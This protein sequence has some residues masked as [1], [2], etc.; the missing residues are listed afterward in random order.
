MKSNQIVYAYEDIDVHNY[1]SHFLN[2]IKHLLEKQL[3]NQIGFVIITK[4]DNDILNRY[5]IKLDLIFNHRSSIIY[6][7]GNTSLVELDSIFFTCLIELMH[8]IP[9]DLLSMENNANDNEEMRLRLH[10]NKKFEVEETFDEQFK[11][12]GQIL[13]FKSIHFLRLN[14]QLIC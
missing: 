13:K 12:V 8:Q 1:I 10:E 5:L 4:D 14:I 2:Q 6:P 3:I 11:L 7:N 9:V